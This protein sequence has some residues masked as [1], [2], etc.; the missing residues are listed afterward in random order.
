MQHTSLHAYKLHGMFLGWMV[1]RLGQTVGP[2]MEKEV[3]TGQYCEMCV[4][5]HPNS[6]NNAK[7]LTARK[8]KTFQI[9]RYNFLVQY[10]TQKWAIFFHQKHFFFQTNEKYCSSKPLTLRRY[11]Y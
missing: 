11:L 1:A 6:T 5:Q 9:Y 2:A 3:N 10:R 7:I 8:N 4:A